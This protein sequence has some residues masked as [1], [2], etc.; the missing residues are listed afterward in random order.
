MV[1][2]PLNVAYSDDS[3]QVLWEDGESVFSRGWR[4][5]DNGNRLAVL[6]VASAA[7]HPS[8]T[9]ID[10]LT[11]EY[12]LKDELDGA[13]AA[14]PLALMRDAGRTVLVLD[15][16]GGEP[17]DRLLGR[18]MEVGRF[19]RLA[20]A[21]TS[22]LG[23]LHQRGLIHKDIKPANIVVDCA[24]GHVRLTGFGIASRLSRE[25][26][27]PQPPETIAGTLAYMA[28]EQ[29]GR[30]NRS[31]DARSDLYALGVT[32]Y[33]MLTGALPFTAADPMEWVHCHIARPPEPPSERLKDLPGSV[34]AIIMKLLAKT[35]E[36][37]YQTAAGAESD[38]RRCL[39][40]W[41]TR[42]DI[43]EF[44]PGEHDT[45]DR[46]LIPEKLYGR[47]AEI[48]TLLASFDRIV[49]GGRP[50][51]VLVSGYSG[52][53]KSAVVN[54][55]HKP[56]VLP[57]GLFASGKF[58]QYKR[59]I[60]YATL[61][62]AFQSLIRPL[63]SKAEAELRQW[64]EAL[65]E[66][67]EPNGR[68]IV[69]LVPELKHIIGEQPPVLELPPQEA[70]GR[71]QLVFR[72]FIS[73]FA[74]PEHP[75]ALFLDDLQWL[76]AATL[77]LLEDLLTRPDVQNLLL[78][79][80]YRDNEVDPIHPLMR[81]LEAMR[82]AGAI[83]QDIVLAPLTCED[84]GQL[85]ADS[86]HSEA[87][88][89]AP[90]AQ[91]IH[92]KTT[93]N[94]LFAI[95]FISAL[96]DEALLTFDYGEARWCWDLNRIHAQGY[97][98]NVV[99][100]M[101]G[102]LNRLSAET[103]NALQKLACLGNDA[104]FTTLRIVYQDSAEEMN[105]QLWEAVRAGLIFRSEDSYKFLH[106]RV[107]EA[108]YSL[109]PEESRAEAHLRI[110]MLLAAKT[111][112]EK[113]EE[114]IFEIVNQLNRGSHLIT[115]IEELEQGAELYL[116]AGR[117]AKTSTAYA[118]ALNYLV[119]GVALLPEDSWERQHDLIF[120]LE[121]HRAECEFLT[122]ALAE[123]EQ[124]LRVLSARAATTIERARVTCLQV[125][126]YLTLDQ[127]SRAIAVGLDYLRQLAID[128]SPHPTEGEARREYE[129]IWSQ[130]GSRTIESLIDL[131]L[132]SN[133]ESLATLDV[134]TKLGPPAWH[135]DANLASLVICRAVNLS[136]EGGNSDGSCYAYAVLGRLAGPKFGDYQAGLLFCRLGYELVEQRGLK[137]FQ[138]RIYLNF[139]SLVT[140]W[141]RHVREG[142][143]LLRRAFE[144]ANQI[145]DLT[146]A[147]YCCSHLNTNL[148]A[149]GD[150][151]DEVQG[152]AERG[153]AFAQKMRFGLAIDCIAGQL[154]LIWTLRGLT[155]IFGRFDDGQFD[156]L[157]LESRFCTNPDLALAEGWYWV[158]KLQARFFA[159]DYASAIEASLRAQ[160]LLWTSPS[161]F[162]T[163]EYHFYSALSHAAS[164]EFAV[165]GQQH[166]DAA[167]AHHRQLEV[168]ARACPDNFENRAALVGAE[169]ARIEG[170]A[171]DAEHLYE[172][173][174]HSAHTHGLVHNEALANEVAAR[175]YAARG[176]ERIAHAY[177]QDARHGY[178]HWGAFGKVRQLDGL[179]PHLRE[180]KPVA[181]PT[182]TIGA[183]VEQLDL[184]TVIKVSQAVSGE[185][186]PEKL[187]DTLMRTAIEHAGAGRGLLI[188]AVGDGYRIEA[189]VTASNNTVTVG[190][191]EASV[192]AAD[193]PE[194]IL[195]YVIRTKESVLLHDAA[196][197]NPF[198][199][200]KYIHQHHARSILCLP[201][202]KQGRLAGVIYLENNLTANVFTPD[203]VTVLKVLASQAAISLENSRLYRDVEDREGK[204]RRLV[205]A[206][207]IGIIIADR[208]GRI[209]EANDAFLR[210]LGYDRE[211][212]VSGR[213]RW[214]D[215][216]PPEWRERDMLTRAELNST[217]IVQP[218]EKEYVRKDGSRVPV[219]IGAALFKEGG[220][221]GLAFVLDL[222]ERKRV[223]EALGQAQRLSRT[224]N[225]IYNA[226]TMRYLYWSD[227]SYRIWG[228][229]PLQG[230]PSRQGVW[231]RI[232][233][234]DRGRVWGAVQEAVD[235]RRDFIAEF[236]LLLPD[237]TIKCVEGT[238][239]H[240]FSPRGTLA[241]VIS[242]TVDV[243][244]RRRAQDEHERLHQLE[245][246][247]AHMNR[248]STMGELA[249]SLSHEI[250]HP[251][252]TAS[253]NAWA[254]MRFL[255]MS[256]PKLD[257][258]RV[259][260]GC[261]V[262]D[263]GRA[264]D[265]VGRMRDQIRK[266]PPRKERFDLNEAIDEVI[267]MV[268]ST[269]AK[270]RIV[271]RT[272]LMNGLV[273]IWGDRVQLQQVLVNLILNAVEAMS[274]VEEVGRELAIRTEQSQTDGIL[275][276]VSD[277][278]SGIDPENRE[279]VFEPFYTTKTSGVGMG[280][281]ICH[282]IIN[283]HGGRLW[284]GAN[285]P[286]GAVFKFTLPVVQ[287]AS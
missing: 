267:V 91:L 268:R 24:D 254:G 54:E 202:L 185:I 250:L 195:R 4:L 186:V 13:W 97:T 272:H 134:L 95:Q 286:R 269:I 222:T 210:I 59:D 79:G 156:E 33:Q 234:E 205:D 125:D 31:I 243:T 90:L 5:D 170:R 36:E 41:E 89:I 114:M 287:E 231:E 144:T 53:G 230:L 251:I 141:T 98:D 145:G 55:L 42:G 232:H 199:A 150:P 52:I 246:D 121:L 104:G 39:A 275:V 7:D 49:A 212:L 63:L 238:S 1:Q 216:S 159:G 105:G 193:L 57:R 44:P 85:I 204:I 23:K 160:R 255:E 189:E 143:D 166:V 130:L 211:D 67:L 87:E 263:A 78:I 40:E 180:E 30:M 109:I 128:W 161:M 139:G 66:A 92:E 106:D 76:D 155:P 126:L 93:G 173:A 209:L 136:L 80:A 34:S 77:D 239:H 217:G 28:P 75:L 15:D 88:R 101:V 182:S 14:R 135:T 244:E 9:R 142:R 241:E 70:Q 58:D 107:Q 86:V 96:A 169:I 65:L 110:G 273:P 188:L 61:A 62:Q 281:S 221:E 108:A 8:R 207:I 165:A 176:F 197:A 74:R 179:Y 214:A 271:V 261:V 6:L 181:G 270:N 48:D 118:S 137:R 45:P 245:S 192:T 240:V 122:G 242:T 236:R 35:A 119:S 278:G 129:R 208:E 133:A 151:L 167:A 132:M 153:L 123:A 100:L 117:R 20:V 10:R 120:E 282:T 162:E 115:S 178:T 148:L 260:L 157:L 248:V 191:R 266:A 69:D 213:V 284:V 203:R 200:D 2:Q 259:A 17:L 228:F 249:A 50:E 218:F 140:P 283:G 227:E 198:S 220:D 103:R 56:L 233:P 237:G 247:F 158:R 43:D 277:S 32:L 68:L 163:A 194:S 265:I 184:A 116:I 276:A 60:P 171:L 190:Q 215:L 152:E 235:Q 46:L 22:A 223:E 11:H 37:R 3:S 183:P 206:N 83:L 94:P 38:L 16:P 111:P 226:T 224:G 154:R 196:V 225:W 274:S 64:R 73:V 25:R 21:V 172:R 112:P 18:P 127:A 177:L 12:E 262:R 27:A 131:P 149:A 47:T 219:L 258:A 82:Q 187:I 72:R 29:T 99:D 285:E 229:D 51:L 147:A 164:C 124:R 175:F 252:A 174:I 71:F 81:K 279:R 113:L 168:W 102:R 146:F 280:L 26:Q 19:L 256:P 84:L 257:K 201:L 138:A 264:K 253:N